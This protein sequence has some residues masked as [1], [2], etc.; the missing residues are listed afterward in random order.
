MFI[1]TV[2]AVLLIIGLTVAFGLSMTGIIGPYN[3][4]TET[5]VYVTA[6]V[7]MDDPDKTFSLIFV[8]YTLGPVKPNSTI[9]WQVGKILDEFPIHVYTNTYYARLKDGVADINPN[10]Y[11][12]VT[13]I[14][15]E[16]DEFI[17]T[18][19]EGEPTTPTGP[20]HLASLSSN[21]MEWMQEYVNNTKDEEV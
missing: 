21:N 15:W 17:V 9:Y 8:I 11:E 20:S 19:V 1:L 5:K 2:I 7:K 4:A 16:N 6:P 3:P 12:P 13:S 14:A 18:C 10:W